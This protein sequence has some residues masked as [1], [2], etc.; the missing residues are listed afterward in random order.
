ME[1][2]LRT[3]FKAGEKFNKLTIL[4]IRKEGKGIPLTCSVACDCGTKKSIKLKAVTS[5]QIKSCGCLGRN[6][7]KKPRKKRQAKVPK[8]AKERRA[9]AKM[10][11][12]CYRPAHRAYKYYGERGIQVCEAW[13]NSFQQFLED[14]G[15][16]PTRQHSVD[17]IN[18]DGNYCKENCRWAT[19]IEQNQNRRDN[20]FLTIMGETRTISHWARVFSLSDNT[21]SGRV[22][23]GWPPLEA[24][25]IPKGEPFRHL[26]GMEILSAFL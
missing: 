26:T 24:L 11:E 22:Q 21:I 3:R 19:P 23:R 13:R 4:E 1:S 2:I 8:N 12:R 6:R 7:P 16:A 5:G 17:R 18:N 9:W 14:M 15:S 25:L 20:K 10:K